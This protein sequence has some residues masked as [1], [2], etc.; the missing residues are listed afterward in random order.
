MTWQACGS[1]EGSHNYQGSRKVVSPEQHGNIATANAVQAPW[2]RR[3]LAK[4]VNAEGQ[5][6]KGKAA[7]QELEMQKCRRDGMGRLQKQR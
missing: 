5:S 3:Y 4:E 6:R 7:G 1:N 2:A